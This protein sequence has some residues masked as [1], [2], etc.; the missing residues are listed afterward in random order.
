LA[1]MRR[2]QSLVEAVVVADW[3]L[4]FIARDLA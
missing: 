3:C 4:T 1:S 2:I